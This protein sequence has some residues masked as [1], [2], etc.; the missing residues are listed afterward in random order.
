[1]SGLSGLS[2]L[3]ASLFGSASPAE[4]EALVNQEALRAAAAAAVQAALTSAG[5]M[6][7]AALVN[8]KKEAA[9]GTKAGEE[10]GIDP[11]A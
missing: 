1:M 5:G 8:A 11:V 7:Q 9:A 3:T 6:D 10:T 4:V 2:G